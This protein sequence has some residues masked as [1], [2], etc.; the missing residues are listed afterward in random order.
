MK[1][2]LRI[3]V[4]VMAVVF[5]CAAALAQTNAAKPT[6]T[7][8]DA[9]AALPKFDHLGATKAPPMHFR[10]EAPAPVPQQQTPKPPAP[11]PQAPQK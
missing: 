10:D 11:E 7:K 5:A 8:P 3:A 6:K 1:R 2:T 4:V 9:G